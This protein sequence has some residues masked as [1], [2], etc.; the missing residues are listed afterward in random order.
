[1]WALLILLD[2]ILSRS[3][4][5]AG[6]GVKV[7]GAQ[8]LFSLIPLVKVKGLARNRCILEIST[9]MHG[10]DFFDHGVVLK[11]GELEEMGSI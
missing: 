2:V 3:K 9:W 8:V 11:E 1:M 4:A 6:I 7:T 5:K 10:F